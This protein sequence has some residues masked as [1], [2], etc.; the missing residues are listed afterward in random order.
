MLLFLT[1]NKNRS[2]LQTLKSEL[3]LEVR[4]N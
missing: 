1:E 4:F 2:R 3:Y